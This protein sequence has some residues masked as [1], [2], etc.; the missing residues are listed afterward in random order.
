MTG[1]KP[2]KVVINPIV[3]RGDIVKCIHCYAG[4]DGKGEMLDRRDCNIIIRDCWADNYDNIGIDGKL[5][6]GTLNYNF[7]ILNTAYGDEWIKIS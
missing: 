6:D 4:Y 1:L 7:V 2:K 3:K 5:V